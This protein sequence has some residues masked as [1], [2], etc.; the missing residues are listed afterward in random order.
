MDI[1]GAII[2]PTTLELWIFD[3]KATESFSLHH[4]KGSCYQ[5]D[6]S[7][8]DVNFDHLG[9]VVCQLSPLRSYLCLYFHTVLF[10]RD[11]LGAS[12]T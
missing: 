10:G 4:I 1:L 7:L 6:L 3:T 11:S 9:E 8:I 2:L 12:H 5:H